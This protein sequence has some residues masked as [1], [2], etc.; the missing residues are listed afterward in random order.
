MAAR[1]TG[2]HRLNALQDIAL[3]TAALGGAR[4]RLVSDLTTLHHT[5]LCLLGVPEAA[6]AHLVSGPIDPAMGE[7]QG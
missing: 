5:L 4:H 1:P 7:M 2:D 6:Y 3:I